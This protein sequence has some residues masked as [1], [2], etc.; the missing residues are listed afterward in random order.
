MADRLERLTD[1]LTGEPF[2]HMLRGDI[3]EEG[4]REFRLEVSGALGASRLMVLALSQVM[5]K[6][7]LVD[8]AASDVMDEP[9]GDGGSGSA[10]TGAKG[11]D[12]IDEFSH[13]RAAR[14]GA[15]PTG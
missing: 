6:L 10:Q 4:V 1:T 3:D 7:K 12:P 9:T 8:G 11:G 15:A 5:T 13:A 2:V 14:R